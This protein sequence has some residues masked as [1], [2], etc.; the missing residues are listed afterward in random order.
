MHTHKA[1]RN[2]GCNLRLAAPVVSLLVLMFCDHHYAFLKLKKSLKLINQKWVIHLFCFVLIMANPLPG[3]ALS[4]MGVTSALN[5]L[6][7]P[8][9]EKGSLF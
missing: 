9:C 8:Q 5:V 6:S 7:P 2:K 4:W 3:T 1:Q